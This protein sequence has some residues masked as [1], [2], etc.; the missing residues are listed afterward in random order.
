[1]VVNR[2]IKT[3][4]AFT[5]ENLAI[6]RPGTGIEPKYIYDIVGKKAS[7]DLGPEKMLYWSDIVF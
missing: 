1:V 6:K 2:H 3:G 4:E 7:R 5:I